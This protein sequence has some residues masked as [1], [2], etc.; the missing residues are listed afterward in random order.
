[1]EQKLNSKGNSRFADGEVTDLLMRIVSSNIE[2]DVE[3][4]NVLIER[5]SQS[6]PYKN[7]LNLFCLK[8]YRNYGA[9]EL[10]YCYDNI[11]KTEYVD[12]INRSVKEQYLKFYRMPNDKADA[13]WIRKSISSS[14]KIMARRAAKLWVIEHSQDRFPG[15]TESLVQKY[16][17]LRK[18]TDYAVD[19]KNTNDEIVDAFYE[20]TGKL[21]SWQTINH[22]KTIF[23]REPEE[24]VS[25]NYLMKK[26][27]A[28]ATNEENCAEFAEFAESANLGSF[29][30]RQIKESFAS[31]STLD[32]DEESL[33]VLKSWFMSA[34]KA[35]RVSKNVKK[36]TPGMVD[37]FKTVDRHSILVEFLNQ[38]VK[39]EAVDAR[40]KLMAFSGLAAMA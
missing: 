19:L 34:K 10:R 27:L 7:A 35:K 36:I 4:S 14:V 12:D 33:D 28:K 29:T 31:L 13:E 15:L 5:F 11:S 25:Q 22:L 30:V 9:K 32:I 40:L 38:V 2:G 6:T 24:E 17:C 18:S 8:A 23:G 16:V 1:M 37:T 21:L 39:A 3:R 26:A 20:A